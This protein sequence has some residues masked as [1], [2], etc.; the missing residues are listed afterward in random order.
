MGHGEAYKQAFKLIF[1]VQIVSYCLDLRGALPLDPHQKPLDPARNS[2]TCPWTLC[3]INNKKVV[4]I[5]S[6]NETILHLS[7]RSPNLLLVMI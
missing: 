4:D 7:S 5:N 1:C 3:I 6:S 2:H